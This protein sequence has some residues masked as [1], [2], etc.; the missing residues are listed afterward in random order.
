MEQVAAW[1]DTVIGNIDDEATIRRVAEE[2]RE[3]CRGF[4]VPG[5]DGYDA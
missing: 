1:I 3:L 5:A 2:V 4:P